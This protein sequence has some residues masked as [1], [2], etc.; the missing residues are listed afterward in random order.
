MSQ[1]INLYNPLFRKQK[2]YF[3]A[4]TMLEALGL[5][6]L[7]SLLFYGYVGY[8]ASL[9]EK[10][11]DEIVQSSKATQMRLEQAAAEFGV[12]KPSPL[13]AAEIARTDGQIQARRLIIEQLNS[14]KLGD[15]Q[16]F[17]EYFRALARQK[18]EGLWITGFHVS[19]TGTEMA[20]HGRALRPELVPAFIHRLKQ[21]PMLAGRTFTLL[22]I[23]L[24]EGAVTDDDKTAPKPAY[25]E[26]SLRKAETEPA[27]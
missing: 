13:L 20:I 19:G 27:K 3:S 24:P 10:R 26:F 5:I 18:P 2:K 8:R 12:R 11:A 23:R 22:E 9:M 15:T 7:G 1:Q 4:V 17:S 14:G 16:G 21:E 6:L 25:V